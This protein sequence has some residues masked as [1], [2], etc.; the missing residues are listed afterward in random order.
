MEQATLAGL[1]AG[2]LAKYQ[3]QTPLSF[4]FIKPHL[5]N[6]LWKKQMVDASITCRTSRKD[7]TAAPHFILV[8][9]DMRVDRHVD[10]LVELSSR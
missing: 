4:L 6:P 8:H 5:L 10:I 9:E 7:S 2:G 1:S 3:C